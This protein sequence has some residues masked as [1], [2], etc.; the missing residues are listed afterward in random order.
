MS[1][2]QSATRALRRP[3][4]AR[5]TGRWTTPCRSPDRCPMVKYRIGHDPLTGSLLARCST[6]PL[7]CGSSAL[8]CYDGRDDGL[9]AFR[10]SCCSK[11]I[12]RAC[13]ARPSPQ[14]VAAVQGAAS[15]FLRN[16]ICLILPYPCFLRCTT[17]FA[18]RWRSSSVS[19]RTVCVCPS[20]RN[21]IARLSKSRRVRIR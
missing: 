13:G 11:Y 15:G 18:T 14:I 1:G 7:H 8:A 4:S 6:R 16:S 3:Q 19:P 21:A 12:E 10:E 5:R 20:A 17:S 9:C 2:P